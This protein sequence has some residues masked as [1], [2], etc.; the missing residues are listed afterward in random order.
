MPCPSSGDRRQQWDWEVYCHGMLQTRCLHHSG[1][2]RWG[3]SHAC[4]WISSLTVFTT[5]QTLGVQNLLCSTRLHL[6]EQ[7]YCNIVKYYITHSNH[8]IL[9][10]Q[11]IPVIKADFQHHY[12]S[13]QCHMIFRNHSNMRIVLTKRVKQTVIIL[14]CNISFDQYNASLLLI[15]LKKIA[16][17]KLLIAIDIIII[18]VIGSY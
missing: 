13:L 7:K 12:S 9:I 14:F 6:F 18:A 8:S 11:F 4:P 2:T 3:L 15:S 10:M 16:E 5:A 17:P 1:G